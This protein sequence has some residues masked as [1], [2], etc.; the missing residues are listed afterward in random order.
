MVSQDLLVLRGQ[1]DHKDS[2]E[3]KVLVVHKELL[4]LKDLLVLK[5]LR[6]LLVQRLVIHFPLLIVLTPNPTHVLMETAEMH[7]L[8]IQLV[9]V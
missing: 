3:H 2:K 1:L 7:T 4:V 8:G 6:V 5:E 9:R